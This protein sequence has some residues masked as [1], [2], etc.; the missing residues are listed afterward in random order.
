MPSPP[1]GPLKFLTVTED[2][3]ELEWRPP[4]SD[5]GSPL[6]NYV[7]EIRESRRPNFGRAGT[8]SASVTKFTCRKLVVGNEYFFRIRAANAEGESEPLNGPEGVSPRLTQEAPGKP[9]AL[10]VP[11][12]T[13]ENVTLEWK[14]PSNDGGARI[15]EY[16]IQVFFFM[17]K[18]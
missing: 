9:T 18:G 10:N 15:K 12:S 8:C 14:A 5:G 13:S 16:I 1:Q 6:L 3:C 2:S 4:V 11:K 7:I 17:K